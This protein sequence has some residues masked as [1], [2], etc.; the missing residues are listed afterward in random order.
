MA[1]HINSKNLPPVINT[2]IENVVYDL[3]SDL[4]TIGKDSFFKNELFDEYHKDFIQDCCTCTAQAEYII[5][6][7]NNRLRQYWDILNPPKY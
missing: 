1:K 7:V 3:L 6:Y 4:K 2:G 5:D